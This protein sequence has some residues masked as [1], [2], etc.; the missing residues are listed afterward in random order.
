MEMR[1]GKSL[2]TIR[3]IKLL[4]PERVLIMAPN[5]ALGSWEREL[6]REGE[7]DVVY[8][9]GSRQQRVELLHQRHRWNLINREGWLALPEIGG[10][11]PCVH[12]KGR[13]RVLSGE[14]SKLCLW[15]RGRKHNDAPREERVQWDAVVLDE[16]T[17][18]KNPRSKVTKFALTKL[19]PCATHRY[20]LTGVPNPEG[21][22]DLWSQ[23]AWLDGAAFGAKTF[24]Q[25]RERYFAPSMY[26]VEIT[27]HGEQTVR[28]MTR[29]RAFIC[30]RRDAQ[31]PDNS[32]RERRELELPPQW[33]KIYQDMHTGFMYEL[34]G[35]TRKTLYA[36][37]A[38]QW[39]R[40]LSGGFA[41]G[42]L[43]WTGKLDELCELLTGE[44]KHEKVVVWFAYNAEVH[45]AYQML[46][47]KIACERITGKTKVE[48]RRAVLDRFRKRH[49]HAVRVLLL[50]QKIAEYG[51]DLSCSDTA[52]YYSRHASL[53]TN[54]QCGD[55][56]VHVRKQH[57]TLLH[58]DLVTKNTTDELLLDALH[59][60]NWRSQRVLDNY[61]VQQLRNGG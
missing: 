39:M 46:K 34:M 6:Q 2:P 14:D 4:H 52:I 41:D 3:R 37:A 59:L 18:I 29:H 8:L 49:T 21:P 20:I 35:E 22:Q 57:H 9:Q 31:M 51:M 16:S 55:R 30:S 19:A 33:L 56:I 54:R 43:V 24:W 60:K 1:T 40:Q 25:F 38:W 13:G 27:P 42:K 32:V 44:L 28:R 50:Q 12:C 10:A 58:L 47:P 15:C 5:S 45:A 17:F 36:I 11:V 53:L 48:Q 23:F 7:E 26:G 61:V